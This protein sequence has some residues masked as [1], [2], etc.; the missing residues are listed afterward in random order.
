[1]SQH[2]ICRTVNFYPTACGA[3]FY[4]LHDHGE[5]C[6]Y[7]RLD[8]QIDMSRH[9]TKVCKPETENFAFSSDKTIRI[10]FQPSLF[11]K[12]LILSSVRDVT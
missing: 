2:V 3:C 11:S 7:S 6:T 5:V 4:P 1:M 8:K 10:I 12:T 9:N